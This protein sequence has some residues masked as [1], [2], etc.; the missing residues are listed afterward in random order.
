M[1]NFRVSELQPNSQIK[2]DLQAMIIRGMCES[3]TEQL[4]Q[5]KWMM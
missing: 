3:Q 1:L 2:Y 5:P 4:S